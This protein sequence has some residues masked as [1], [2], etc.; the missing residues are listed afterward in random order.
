MVDYQTVSEEGM[1]LERGELGGFGEGKGGKSVVISFCIC[2]KF[3]KN[4]K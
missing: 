4:K 2:V 1:K 3:S